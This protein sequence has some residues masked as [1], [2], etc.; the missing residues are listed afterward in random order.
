VPVTAS[1]PSLTRKSK[2]L[3]APAARLLMT[4]SVPLVTSTRPLT[5]SRSNPVPAVAPFSS[6]LRTPVEVCV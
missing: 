3:P 6:M 4:L 1:L 5:L 2:V